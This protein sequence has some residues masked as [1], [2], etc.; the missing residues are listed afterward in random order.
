MVIIS[1]GGAAFVITMFLV[2]TESRDDQVLALVRDGI[3]LFGGRALLPG[4]L[5]VVGRLAGFELLGMDAAQSLMPDE[6]VFF[7]LEAESLRK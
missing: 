3:V 1:A 5:M 2:S 6:K 4:L 7:P